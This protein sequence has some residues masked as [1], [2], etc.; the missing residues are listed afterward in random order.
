MSTVAVDWQKKKKSERNIPSRLPF[1]I[2]IMR[3]F[4]LFH[5]P[6]R[7][8]SWQSCVLGG[9]H[10]NH[11]INGRNVWFVERPSKFGGSYLLHDPKLFVIRRESV[12]PVKDAA[13][14]PHFFTGFFW[15]FF[16]LRV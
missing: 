12:L 9:N 5:P 15:A 7:L 3:W 14:G 13:T 16:I 10:I 6:R 2:K 8:L 4:M 1:L 11:N